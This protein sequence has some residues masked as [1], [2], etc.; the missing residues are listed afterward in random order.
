[1][2]I[3]VVPPPRVRAEIS[4]TFSTDEGWAI[5]AALREYADNHPDA[6]HREEWRKWASDLYDRMRNAA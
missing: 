6:V 3:R 1:M 2:K 5:V 4:L